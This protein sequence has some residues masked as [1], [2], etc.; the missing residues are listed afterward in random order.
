LSGAQ[1]AYNQM[2]YFLG[3]NLQVDP[4]VIESFSNQIIFMLYV[5]IEN[6]L[7][8]MESDEMICDFQ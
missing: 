5:I 6:T 7:E 1:A 4:L 2:L 8:K 3:V